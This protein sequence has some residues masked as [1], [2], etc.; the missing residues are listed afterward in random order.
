MLCGICLAN[1]G[2]ESLWCG[3]HTYYDR[4]CGEFVCRTSEDELLHNGSCLA[5]FLALH[6]TVCLINDEVEPPGFTDSGI[7]QRLPD[8][9]LTGI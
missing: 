1:Q 8:S 3:G 5:S 4:H 2:I 9:E 6:P 7:T